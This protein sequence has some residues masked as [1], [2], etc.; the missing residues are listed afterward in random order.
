M[1]LYRLT[2]NFWEFFDQ[3]LCLYA[4]TTLCHERSL[5][6]HSTDLHC[7]DKISSVVDKTSVDYQYQWRIQ[8]FPEVGRQLSEGRG[9]CQHN[10]LPNF[11]KNCMK[12][13]EFGPPG[14][15]PRGPLDPPL[16][17]YSHG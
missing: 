11:P 8:D 13:K 3:A 7:V 9:G 10:I 6:T 1:A 12:L 4:S 17:T 5:H 2:S 15:V 14:S 16:N